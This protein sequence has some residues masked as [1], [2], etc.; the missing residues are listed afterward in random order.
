VGEKVNWHWGFGLA[1]IGMTIGLVQYVLGEKYLGNTGKTPATVNDPVQAAVD[2]KQF[3]HSLLGFGALAVALALLGGS[4]ILP[5]SAQGIADAMG[6]VLLV[7]VVGFFAWLLFAG[8]WTTVE[9][10]RFVVIM[11]LFFAASLFW[12]AFEQAGST[13]NLFAERSTDRH[14]TGFLADISSSWIPDHVYPASWFQAVN[15]LFIITLAPVIGWVWLR[16]GAK[17]PSTPAKFSLGLVLVGLGYVVLMVGA[18]RAATGVQVSALWLWATYLL[19]T[20]GELCLSPVGLSA[21][22]KLAP[23]RVVGLMMGVW[24]MATSVGNYIGGRLASVYEA[25]TP[26]TLFAVVGGFC[27]GLGLLMFVFVKPM[28][29]MM[30]GVK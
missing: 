22:T 14:L 23:A 29:N 5:I 9:R 20:V 16:L 21:M 7:V 12:S 8:E 15:S 25:F 30:G 1:G 4:G 11:V 18:M 13:L 10:K 19:H 2:K 27:V 17:N 6:V 3:Q 24:F 26:T 28:R